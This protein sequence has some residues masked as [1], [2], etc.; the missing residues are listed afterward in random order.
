MQVR[1]ERGAAQRLV[2]AGHRAPLRATGGSP[3]ASPA[4]AVLAGS[5]PPA[6]VQGF[7]EGADYF[8]PEFFQESQRSRAVLFW[9][10]CATGW[11]GMKKNKIYQ[12]GQ[13]ARG[14]GAT[15][16]GEGPAP[17][18]G[19]GHGRSIPRPGH[20]SP[21]ARFQAAEPEPSPSTSCLPPGGVRNFQ[22][23]L[24]LL[25]GGDFNSPGTPK[26]PSPWLGSSAGC[27]LHVDLPRPQVP[28]SAPGDFTPCP[29][30]ASQP[31]PRPH[32]INPAKFCSGAAPSAPTAP[33]GSSRKESP[34]GSKAAQRP[35]FSLVWFSC[36]P[37]NCWLFGAG[38][39]LLGSSLC[40]FF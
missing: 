27:P 33:S 10:S 8:V 11:G 13:P 18:A 36:L 40:R 9:T 25:E 32:T 37:P 4:P 34:P 35:G 29:L 14:P 2:P 5:S 15:G 6:I 20:G 24:A 30:T 3:I 38:C 23:D 26:P 17:W 12:Q 39:F 21:G 28:S 22:T 31:K 1:D 7:C 16:E 19:T